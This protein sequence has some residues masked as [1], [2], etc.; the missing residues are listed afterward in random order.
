MDASLYQHQAV[1]F[2][3]DRGWSDLMRIFIIVV[4]IAIAA[5]VAL[6]WVAS[7][8]VRRRKARGS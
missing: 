6:I 2:T 4:V 8:Q 5:V 3:V 1:D 7:T